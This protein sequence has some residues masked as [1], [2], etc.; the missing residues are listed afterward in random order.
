PALRLGD[1]EAADRAF[2]V[3]GE[4]DAVDA[5]ER[6]EL[7]LADDGALVVGAD[8]GAVDR[9][10]DLVALDRH[11]DLLRHRLAGAGGL[12]DRRIFLTLGAVQ[13]ERA[14]RGARRESAHDEL[15]VAVGLAIQEG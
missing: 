13:L 5:V 11:R 4:A 15:S 2:G 9:A 7:A 12:V 10:G 6:L 1:R 3:V 8:D 14:A